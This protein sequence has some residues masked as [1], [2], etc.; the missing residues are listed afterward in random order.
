[1]R[2]IFLRRKMKIYPYFDEIEGANKAG[3]TW[4]NQDAN[5]VDV[6]TKFSMD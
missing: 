6:R 3:I 2:L 1:M 4:S 5:P